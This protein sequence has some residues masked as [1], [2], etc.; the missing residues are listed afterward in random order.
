M[1]DVEYKGGNTIM[2]SSKKATIITDPRLSVIGLKDSKVANCVELVTEERFIVD[3]DNAKLIICQ[4]GE[5]EIGNFTIKGIAA[6]R[7]IDSGKSEKLSTIYRI[8]CGNVAVGVLGNIE[9]KLNDDQLEELGV[10]DILIVP[11]GGSG[12]TLDSTSAVN[13][14]RTISPKAVVPVHYADRDITYEVPQDSVDTFVKEMGAPVENVAKLKVKND[15]SLPAV[16][17]TYVV[18]RTR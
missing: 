14:V 3:D 13:L 11:V 8:E 18:S 6:V 12:Y 15:S 2:L 17:T 1:F 7:H 16:L 4:P 5:Y 9:P 10:I